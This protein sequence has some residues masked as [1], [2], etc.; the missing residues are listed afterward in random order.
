M[1]NANIQCH[2]K[3]LKITFNLQTNIIQ[4]FDVQKSALLH[5]TT[6]HDVMDDHNFLLDCQSQSL[7]VPSS[8]DVANAVSAMNANNTN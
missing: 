3:C 6:R 7:T 2:Q 4:C 8:D 1:K 5:P